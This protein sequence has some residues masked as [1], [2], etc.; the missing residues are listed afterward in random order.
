MAA[1]TFTNLIVSDGIVRAAFHNDTET[2]ILKSFSYGAE[3]TLEIDTIVQKRA[4]E[5][6]D[7][8]SRS[9]HKIGRAGFSILST[10]L[11]LVTIFPI[12][13]GY[14]YISSLNMSDAPWG[15]IGLY[16]F[17]TLLVGQI[18][19][20]V[21]TMAYDVQYRQFTRNPPPHLRR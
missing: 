5:T 21:S 13:V 18:A 7:R 11:L 4:K 14:R 8:W 15:W 1:S 20:L 6:S 12:F 16:F 17:W 2:G 19:G 3:S 9:L 10:V